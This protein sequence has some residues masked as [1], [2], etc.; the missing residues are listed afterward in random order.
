MQ[1]IL[2]VDDDR[3]TRQLA[4]ALSAA[5]GFLTCQAWSWTIFARTTTLYG[6]NLYAFTFYMLTGLH[7][8]H[9]LGGLIGLV[10]T[11]VRARRGDD[12]RAHDPGVRST[13]LYWHFLGAVWVV[14]FAT[15][16]LSS[17]A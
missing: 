7:A 2:V 5:L 14:M 11:L 6:G 1:R 3:S 4:A 17:G 15:L 9:V 13:A 8:L 16:L 12:S 10:V